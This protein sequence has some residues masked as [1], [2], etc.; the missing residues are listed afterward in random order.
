MSQITTFS[1]E[2]R[3]N[4]LDDM[5]LM[6]VFII[7][8]RTGLSSTHMH[9]RR[10]LVLVFCRYGTYSRF[11]SAKQTGITRQWHHSLVCHSLGKERATVYKTRYYF[12]SRRESNTSLIS[13]VL[14]PY[15]KSPKCGNTTLS[16]TIT[17]I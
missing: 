8:P 10:I 15:G 6:F 13:L 16:T 3:D 2:D 7:S 4:V 11:R 12:S 14:Y 9:V 5:I 17:P 1:L